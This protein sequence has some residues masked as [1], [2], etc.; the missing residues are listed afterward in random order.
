MS[1][2]APWRAV[3]DDEV[4][5]LGATRERRRSRASLRPARSTSA[6]ADHGIPSGTASRPRSGFWKMQPAL[7]VSSGCVRLRNA[8]DS[9]A[10][11]RSA[12]GSPGDTTKAAESSDLSGPLQAGSRSYPKAIVVARGF[13]HDARRGRRG[14]PTTRARRS[15]GR[16]SGRCRRSRRRPS[17]ACRPRLRDRRTHG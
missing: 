5:V 14:E 3:V 12:A 8:S 16:R 7:G 11:R 4:A 9:R 1:D 17:P 13:A 6:P 15:G 10:V 2:R